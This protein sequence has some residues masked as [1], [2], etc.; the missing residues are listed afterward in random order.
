MLIAALPTDLHLYSEAVGLVQH[1]PLVPVSWPLMQLIAR[2]RSK[3]RPEGAFLRPTSQPDP[4]VKHP[5]SGPFNRPR[6]LSTGGMSYS[7][8]PSGACGPI[9]SLRVSRLPNGQDAESNIA[10]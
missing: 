4:G 7:K 2:P 1:A 6:T 3:L 10:D 5:F 9:R 8:L